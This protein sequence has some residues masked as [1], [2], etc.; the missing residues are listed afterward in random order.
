M[1]QLVSI[2]IPAFN[3]EKWIRVCIESALAQTWPRKEI[4]IVDDGSRDATLEIARSYSS[5]NVRVATQDNRGASAAR[6]HALSLAQGDFVQWL[7]ADDLLAPDKIAR[8]LESAEPGH[9]SRVLLCGAWGRFYRCPEGSRFIPTA[10]WEDLEPVEWLFRKVDQNL[11]MA[12]DSWL[13]SRRLTEMAG[14][15]N[16]TLYLDDDGEYFCRVLS[17][18]L[19]IRFIPEA[20]CYCRMGGFASISH[21]LNLSDRKLNSQLISIRSYI[22]RLRAMGDSPRTRAACLKLLRRWAIY[23]YPERPDLL[24]QLQHMATDLGGRLGPPT[25][26]A[27]YRWLQKALGWR[28]A[29]KA[30]IALP[31]LRSL[32]EKHWER[33]SC[34]R[35]AG[36]G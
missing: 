12:I 34:L 25:L 29:K 2:L 8:Q 28:I 14:P 31:T 13:V 9:S 36:P 10:L 4:V 11:W 23:F 22:Q 30:Q 26:R 1:K 6:N 15:W 27:K 16:E 32:L 7:D 20:R 3:S 17:C 21:G 19:G 5:P 24:R 33:L 35:S 18:S